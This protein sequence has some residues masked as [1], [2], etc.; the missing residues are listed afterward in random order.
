MLCSLKE[1]RSSPRDGCFSHSS[2]RSM[3]VL[4]KSSMVNSVNP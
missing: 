3:N 4:W 2:I 1:P